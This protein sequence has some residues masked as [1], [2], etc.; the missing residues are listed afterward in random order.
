MASDSEKH[1]STNRDKHQHHYT[2]PEICGPDCWY[3]TQ[4]A[5]HTANIMVHLRT[6]RG[7]DPRVPDNWLDLAHHSYECLRAN[8]Y[9][10]PSAWAI[11]STLF[12]V[13]GKWEDKT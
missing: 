5:V 8:G 9:K 2:Q 3:N 6:T 12:R 13:L 7:L 11:A 10:T 4:H 1:A